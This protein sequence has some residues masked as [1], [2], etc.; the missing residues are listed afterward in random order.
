MSGNPTTDHIESL[1]DRLRRDLAEIAATVHEPTGRP[2]ASTHQS[3]PPLLAAAA[4]V[5]LIVGTVAIFA[6]VGGDDDVSPVITETP[7]TT[8]PVATT[9][10][11]EPTTAD[12][13]ELGWTGGLLDDLDTESLRPLESF[14]D[15][16]VIVPTGPSGWR[17]ADSAWTDPAEAVAPDFVEWTV[18]VIEPKER[19]GHILHLTVSRE[20]RCASVRGCKPSGESVTVNGVVWESIVPEDWPWDDDDRSDPTTLRARVGDRW[21]SLN[22]GAPQALTGPLH[23]DS[24]VLAFLDGLRAGSPDDV[25]A[26]GE[27]CW[28]CGTAGG[29][30]DP[31]AAGSPPL[32]SDP[33]SATTVDPRAQTPSDIDGERGRPLTELTEGD[34]VIPTY[35]PPGLT[36]DHSVRFHE[37]ARGG[38][39]V[40]VAL[41]TADN[42]PANAVRLV[43]SAN[44][45]GPL[46]PRHLDDPNHPPVEIAGLTWGWYDFETAR[47][48]NIGQFSIWVYLHGLDRLQA[49]RFINGLRA[50]PGEQFPGQRVALDGDDGL[51]VLDVDGRQ[52]A[53]VVAS[54]DRFELTAVQVGDQVCTKLTETT[55]PVT[56]MWTAD[57]WKSTRFTESG[58][59]DLY[60]LDAL[61]T[62]HMIIGVVDSPNATAVQITAPDGES[63]VVPTGPA[64]QTIDGR[65]FLAQ[66]DLDISN[67]I[68][69]DRFTVEDASP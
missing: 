61:D 56:M 69:F 36:L 59:H 19:F 28:Q 67:G 5:V 34:I 18:E 54:N 39:D 57:C 9:S 14:G 11:P 16:D 27:A 8:A 44:D 26:I 15:G 43:S 31:F 25:A 17:L 66:I 1:E 12:E 45:S 40:I 4:V 65:F 64:N 6:M 62:T 23:D 41:E 55:V 24:S 48:A 68:V 49:E 33:A 21:V 13:L 7:T 58:I 35:I 2:G 51:S 3:R 37:F 53:E 52:N 20:P 46:S 30:G 42:Q 32:A 50:V 63:V 29:E 60:P 38:S 10:V 22:P 47:I